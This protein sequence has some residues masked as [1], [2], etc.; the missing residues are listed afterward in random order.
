MYTHEIMRCNPGK[1]ACLMTVLT[2]S[3]CFVCVVW[4][5]GMYCTVYS[6]HRAAMFGR[7]LRLLAPVAPRP[8]T[9]HQ[10]SVAPE[11]GQWWPWSR[12]S[13]RAPGPWSPP[14]VSWVTVSDRGEVD[15]DTNPP[16]PILLC[17]SSVKMCV[18]VQF[19]LW[20]RDATLVSNNI[21][22]GWG[23]PTSW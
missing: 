3:V 4:V 10:S 16:S 8:R 15:T 19:K 12:M 23:A 14:R 2:M 1:F 17:L 22:A 18:K 9:W 5:C 21:W 13:T 6:V 11:A 20:T 7:Q